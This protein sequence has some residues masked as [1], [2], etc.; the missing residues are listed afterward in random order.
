MK[1]EEI[2]KTLGPRKRPFSVIF[3]KIPPFPPT[4]TS[5]EEAGTPK[6]GGLHGSSKRGF[7]NWPGGDKG[8]TRAS[9]Q[10]PS[11]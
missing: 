2:Q 6:A 5:K 8:K 3:R 10:D 11:E 9:F 7:Q 1:G 4:P